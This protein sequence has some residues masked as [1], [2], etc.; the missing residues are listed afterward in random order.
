[1]RDMMYVLLEEHA[2]KT[3]LWKGLKYK[4]GMLRGSGYDFLDEVD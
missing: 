4:T 3:V 2:L 1:M